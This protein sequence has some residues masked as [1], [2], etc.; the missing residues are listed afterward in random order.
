MIPAFSVGLE[1]W[2]AFT[3]PRLNAAPQALKR[4][5]HP[6]PTAAPGDR[7][8]MWPEPDTDSTVS[9]AGPVVQFTRLN[10]QA[11]VLIP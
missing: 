1:T 2:L 8:Q 5:N 11:L 7:Q 4:P 9:P 3:C 6:K 10:G